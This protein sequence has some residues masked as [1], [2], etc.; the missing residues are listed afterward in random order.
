MHNDT[1]TFAL[2]T[3]QA[4][5]AIVERER[6]NM[7]YAFHM[8]QHTLQG[9]IARVYPLEYRMRLTNGTVLCFIAASAY[10]RMRAM[11]L[12]RI[13]VGS[14]ALSMLPDGFLES[15]LKPGIAVADGMMYR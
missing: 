8:A 6:T 15:R 1:C 5:I 7:R 3:P 13:D 12:D 10:E 2:T 11:R 14:G 9:H 4:H